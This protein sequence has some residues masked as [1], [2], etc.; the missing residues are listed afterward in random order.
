VHDN[1][2]VAELGRLP[3]GY[4]VRAGLGMAVPGGFLWE[5]LAQGDAMLAYRTA[6]R[7]AQSGKVASHSTI[8]TTDAASAVTLKATATKESTR[9]HE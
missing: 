6:Y 4:C 9:Y 5:V 1:C 2:H 7:M 8:Q 3:V